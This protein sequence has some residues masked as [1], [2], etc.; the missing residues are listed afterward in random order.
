MRTQDVI[1]KINSQQQLSQDELQYISKMWSLSPLIKSPKY[2]SDRCPNCN[3]V[4]MYQ[5]CHYCPSCG[6]KITIC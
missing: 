2:N 5:S 6:E 3:R 4:I 1:N